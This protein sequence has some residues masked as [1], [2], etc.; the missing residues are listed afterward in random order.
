MNRNLPEI[1]KVIFNK[2]ATIILWKDGRK[3]VAKCEDGD[4]YNK[5]VGFLVAFLKRFFDSEYVMNLV[6]TYCYSED[7]VV[8]NPKYANKKKVTKT[9]YKDS[10]LEEI[11]K[12]Y[13]EV[14]SLI[15]LLI[16]RIYRR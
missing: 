4:E 13:N 1:E 8:Y 9:N 16:P 12:L 2:P 14:S 5:T 15:D 10:E 7:E 6:D 3:S 11:E